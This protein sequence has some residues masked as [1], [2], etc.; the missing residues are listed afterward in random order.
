MILYGEQIIQITSS[1]GVIFA[2]TNHGNIY[3]G[4][5][6]AFGDID[7]DVCDLPKFKEDEDGGT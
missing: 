3:R 7:W 4:S 6:T 5:N 1:N 2:L